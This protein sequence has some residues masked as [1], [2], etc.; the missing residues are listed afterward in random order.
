MK[1]SL[2]DKREFERR[3][4]LKDQRTDM[5]ILRIRTASR[6]FRS[7]NSP[8]PTARGRDIVLAIAI[9][10]CRADR[11]PRYR[12]G[13]GAHQVGI[14]D[15]QFFIQTDAA[16]NPAKFR[17]RAS[18]SHRA[19]FGINTADLLAL[20]RLAGRRLRHSRQYVQVRDLGKGAA[21]RQRP[22]LGANCSSDAGDRDSMG[23][24]RPTGALIAMWW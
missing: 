6:N 7:S 20:R 19:V 13:A 2:S 17:R 18:R 14:T 16:I 9:I 4:V 8:I 1:V 5:A 12:F 21:R 3:L 22:W 15:Y 11:D 24:Q 10:W 23:P